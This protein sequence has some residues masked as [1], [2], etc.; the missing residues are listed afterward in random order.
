MKPI[1]EM[2]CREFADHNAEKSQWSDR[3]QFYLYLHA[4]NRLLVTAQT[5]QSFSGLWRSEEM[6]EN[7]IYDGDTDSREF[8]QDFVNLFC[9]HLSIHQLN[10]L[11]PAIT[12]MR[13]DWEA[14]REQWRIDYDNGKKL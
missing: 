9:Q 1:H 11:I 13:D 4:N 10:D 8:A 14:E 3:Q 7:G 2:T 12:K 6:A 5:D